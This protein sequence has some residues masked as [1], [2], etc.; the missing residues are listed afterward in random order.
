M[1]R[2]IIINF[3]ICQL[4]YLCLCKIKHRSTFLNTVPKWTICQSY[5]SRKE[6]IFSF[7]NRHFYTR[8]EK[9]ERQEAKNTIFNKENKGNLKLK[10]YILKS[11]KMNVY[12]MTTFFLHAFTSCFLNRWIFLVI[13]LCL[14]NI[15]QLQVIQL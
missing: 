10:V 4:F 2:L 13:N 3:L 15:I 14:R 12:G 1:L 11:R 8:K 7:A 6:E 9:R 5:D